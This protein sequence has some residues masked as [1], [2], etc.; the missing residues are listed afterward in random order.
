VHN[1]TLSAECPLLPWKPRVVFTGVS[2]YT[3]DGKGKVAKH[4]DVWDSCAP[5]ALPLFGGIK[6]ILFGGAGLWRAQPDPSYY[7]PPAVTLYRGTDYELR[8]LEDY[9]TVEMDYVSMP[10]S[11]KAAAVRSLNTYWAGANADGCVLPA[12]QPTLVVVDEPTLESSK[13]IAC[14]LPHDL[15]KGAKAAPEPV[16]DAVRGLRFAQK[17]GGL[18]AVKRIENQLDPLDGWVSTEAVFGVRQRLLRRL[19]QDGV[20]ASQ[21]FWLARYAQVYGEGETIY[22]LWVPVQSLEMR[23]APMLSAAA[24]ANVDLS[25]LKEDLEE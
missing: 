5:E 21:K 20:K 16:G 23:A 3:L 10:R 12:S 6:D 18:F 4:V 25:F 17:N 19:E 11:N 22:E 15:A 2:I 9:R 24:R 14:F 1:R 7:L 8:R 13:T